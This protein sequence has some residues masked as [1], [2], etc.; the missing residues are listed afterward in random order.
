MAYAIEPCLGEW[1]AADVVQRFGA[2]PLHRVRHHPAPGT[3]TEADVVNLSE[4]EDILC[5]L[6]DGALLEKTMGAY[7]TY[8]GPR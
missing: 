2:I 6:V 7:E 3:A 8:L 1:T 4:H 5:E